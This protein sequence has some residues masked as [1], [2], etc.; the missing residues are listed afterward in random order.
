VSSREVAFQILQRVELQ[1]SYADVAIERVPHD[2]RDSD[3]IRTLVLGVIRWRSRLDHAIARL[4]GRDLAKI[5]P[6]VLQILRIG[7]YQLWF[8]SVA[9]Y[10]AISETVD[11]AARHAKS[12][13]GFVNAVLR[14]ASRSRLET[15]DP[16]GNDIAALAIRLAHPEWMLRRWSEELGLE[17]AIA[18][19]RANQELS[20]PDIVVNETKTDA[21][22]VEAELRSRGIAFTESPFI[23]GVFRLE[24]STSRVDDLIARGLVYP[25]DEGSVA[26]TTLVPSAASSI[27]DLAAAPGGKSLHLESRGHRVVSHDISI[28]RVKPLRKFH[29]AMFSTP[30]KLVIGDGR[31]P[32]F[33][34][35]FDA[36][37]LDAPCSASGTIRKNPEIKWR[38]DEKS[39]NDF[40][41]L[42][43]ALLDSACEL[44]E[45]F[46]IYAT[47]SL[48]PEE[49]RDVVE[50]V[51]ARRRDFELEDAE[52][53]VAMGLR[54]FIERG[55]LRLTPETR[56][57]GFTAFLLRRV[58]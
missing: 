20:Y 50:S 9:Q 21:N 54:G 32:G 29:R 35:R 38:L 7:A 26:V 33:R 30:P 46:C 57:D 58:S 48:E 53:H 56:C 44:A 47:C 52:H 5:D 22:S 39:I 27:L 25:M 40:S 49:N 41:E 34:S 10:A 28:S 51:L 37:L 4:A 14:N 23:K 2:A 16:G 12:A 17:R 6:P 24:E 42:Q 15:L 36:V 55:V 13:K 45:R 31:T 43:R 18:I 1:Q 3:F 8:M 19:A 11:V